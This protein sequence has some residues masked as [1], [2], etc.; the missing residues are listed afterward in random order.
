M[1]EE[2]FASL[3][4]KRGTGWIREN[5][6]MREI[7]RLR[8]RTEKSMEYHGDEGRYEVYTVGIATHHII[9]AGQFS[10][11]IR[12]LNSTQ[13]DLRVIQIHANGYPIS[14]GSNDKVIPL[15]CPGRV[16]ESLRAWMLDQGIALRRATIDPM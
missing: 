9:K 8:Q 5:T 12:M 6:S 14:I 11:L 13:R 1:Q 3:L 16:T 15:L 2:Y 10:A 4:Y 7:N